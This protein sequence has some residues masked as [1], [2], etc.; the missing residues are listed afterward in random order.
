MPLISPLMPVP[1]VTS[2]TM[3][4]SLNHHHL[5]SDGRTNKNKHKSDRRWK[6]KQKK[7]KR[8]YMYHW[9]WQR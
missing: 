4:N 9:P 2:S 5:L 3:S 6:Q 8:N 7:W 1:L